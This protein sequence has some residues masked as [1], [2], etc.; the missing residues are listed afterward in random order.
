M[1]EIV[2]DVERIVVTGDAT[3]LDTIEVGA[4]IQSEIAQ[5]MQNANWVKTLTASDV[6]CVVIP[7]SLSSTKV[8]DN[9]AH[10]IAESVTHAL[11]NTT[12]MNTNRV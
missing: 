7:R 12:V 8:N 11:N 9:L 5:M 10:T 4:L 3:T 2:I 6:E 1:S